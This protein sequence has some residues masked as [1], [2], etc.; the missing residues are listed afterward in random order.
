ML[1]EAPWNEIT[2]DI[3]GAAIEVH[4][5]LGPGLLESTY[6]TCLL[7]ELSARKLRHVVQRPIPIVYKGTTLDTAYRVDLIVEET[8]VVE[9]K[10]V[11]RLLAV[12]DAEVITYLLLTGCPA[13]LL[14]NFN[15]AKL[16]DGVKRLVRP[17]RGSGAAGPA[18]ETGHATASS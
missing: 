17:H 2:H 7:F 4:R 5:M 11:E 8:V 6:L 9:I 18:H 3:I 16:T 13:G 14:I 1:I 12:H 15:V 10:S